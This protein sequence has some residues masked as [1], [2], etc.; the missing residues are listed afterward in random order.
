MKKNSI[1]ILIII[2]GIAAAAFLIF[3]SYKSNE[4]SA[5]APQAAVLTVST[6]G[7]TKAE[8]PEIIKAT[9]SVAAWQEAVVGAEI[10]GQ[11]L[12][13]VLADVG[14]VVTKGQ[15]L[16]KF[17]SETLLAEYAEL[18]AN[19]I[20]A[21]SNRKRA[22]N[23]KSFD[24]ISEQSVEDYINRA[25]VAKAQMDAKALHLKYT[26]ITAPD[27]GVISSRSATLGAVGTAGDELFRLIRRNRLEWRGE[28]TAEQ[29]ARIVKG[30]PVVLALPN[31][32]KAEGTVRKTAPSFN[33]ETR[34]VTVFADVAP[35]SSAKSGM[36]AAGFITLRYQTAL[37]IPTKSIVTRDGQNY[38]FS[39]IS[40]TSA[41]TVT[42]RLVKIGQIN[43]GEAQ[44]L[45]GISENDR[46][47]LHGAGFLKDG[48]TVKVSNG[49]GGLQ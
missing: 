49:K 34:M 31:G 7:V 47:V 27:E 21:E 2:A 12:I 16:A 25:E 26:N 6:V 35:G 1:T 45:S 28:L 13:T 17:N 40:G 44:V 42:Q 48:D 24:A 36:Y 10:S 15:L 11:R 5:D 8:W 32:D 37:S 23:L 38:V 4:T 3:K 22:L 19:W 33:P 29:A 14:D 9:G 41:A 30:Q 39:I 18:E 20:T 46:I 43:G